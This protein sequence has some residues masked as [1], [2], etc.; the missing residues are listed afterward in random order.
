MKQSSDRL[1]VGQRLTAED[2]SRAKSQGL[3]AI[4]NIRPDDK[5]AGQPSAAENRS[6]AEGRQ[7]AYAR[8][9]GISREIG[10]SQVRAFQ[11]ALSQDEGPVLA[12]R[13]PGM[14]SRILYTIGEVLGGRMGEDQAIPF[15]QSI[16]L[17]FSGAVQWL[18][19]HGR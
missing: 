15:R 17:G 16:G 4:V 2:I 8:I 1:Y 3:A 7:L 6:V 12:H 13:K 5:E 10:E 14:R 19:A 18:D 9:P 11:A